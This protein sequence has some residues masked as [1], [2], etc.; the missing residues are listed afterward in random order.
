MQIISIGIDCSIG[1]LMKK[2][3]LH[4]M[5]LPFDWNITFDGVFNIINNNFID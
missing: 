4:N 2:Y 3:N 1:L 5:T